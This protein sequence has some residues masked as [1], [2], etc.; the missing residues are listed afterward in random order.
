MNDLPEAVEQLAVRVDA[1]EKRVT[2]LECGAAPATKADAGAIGPQIAATEV[3]SASVGSVFPVLGRALLGIAGAYV[4]RALASSNVLPRP[5]IAAAGIV[6]ALAWLVAAGRA[7]AVKLAA[8]VYAGTSALILAPMLW[9]MCLRFQV[10]P[11]DA[12]AGVLALY[13]AAATWLAIY[14]SPAF[15]FAYAGGAMAALALSIGTHAMAPF[16]LLLMSMLLV[17]EIAQL[18][19]RPLAI[20]TL[21]ALTADLA[22][23]TVVFIYRMPPATRTDYPA[24]GTA[25]VVTIGCLPF[26]ITFSGIAW[27]TVRMGLSLNALDIVHGILSFVVAALALLWMLPSSGSIVFGWLCVALAFGCYAATLTAFRRG[28][29]RVNFRAGAV[30][31]AILVLAGAFLLLDPTRAAVALGVVALGAILIGDRLQCGAVEWHGVLYLGIAAGLS[32]LVAYAGHALMGQMPAVPAWPVLAVAAAAI[33][34]Y[35]AG[36][37]RPGEAGQEQFLHFVPALLAALAAVALLTHGIVRAA[38]QVLPPMD[39]HIAFLRTL[40]LCAVALFLAFAASRWQRVELKRVAYTALAFVAAK[41]I[42][43]D[44]RHGHMEFTAAS[45]GLVALTLIAV[46]RLAQ[47]KTAASAATHPQAS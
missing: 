2:Q 41:L 8:A 15:S 37:E 6:Y 4:L 40:T 45:I 1:L 24:L 34:A 25:A 9:E 30:W 5:L 42:F 20:R 39:F 26:V 23:W 13:A 36:D 28:A 35:A 21:I 29:H 16:T 32:G 33:A 27:R 44:L 12:A 47:R 43:E 38:A 18:R 46:P 17:C 19:Q 10:L 7:S 22:A 11:A 3:S 14:R 31:S